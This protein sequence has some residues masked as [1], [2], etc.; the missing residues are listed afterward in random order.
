MKSA[1]GYIVA[2]L[3]GVPLTLLIILWLIGVGR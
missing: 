2:W 1:F 3:L